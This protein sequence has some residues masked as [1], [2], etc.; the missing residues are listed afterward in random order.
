MRGD[1]GDR[2]DPLGTDRSEPSGFALSLWAG[3]AG[4]ALI[5]A[6]V[7][8]QYGTPDRNQ[9][10]DVAVL[11]ARPVVAGSE[12][13]ADFG[14]STEHMAEVAAELARQ[15]VENAG[16]R[17]SLDVMRGQID[18]LSDRIAALESKLQDVTGT[19]SSPTAGQSAVVTGPD[20]AVVGPP[21]AALDLTADAPPVS[22]TRFGVELG[23]FADLASLR[24]A[25]L[26][27]RRENPSVFGDLT[28]LAT[29]RDRD[30]DTELLL[31]AG[32]FS[33]ASDA[34]TLCGQLARTEMTCLPAFYVGQPL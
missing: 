7:A 20:F 3:V 4:L 26:R 24:D 27:I 16:L 18:G 30:G 14:P 22:H 12:S 8:W 11:P 34:A 31:V 25:W 5:L 33:N 15:R 28:A 13:M 23:A 2:F 9:I 21:D 32:P 19:L 10:D 17:K 6:L 29:I 1:S